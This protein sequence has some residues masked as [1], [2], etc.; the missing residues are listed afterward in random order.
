MNEDEFEAFPAPYLVT[1]EGV[2]LWMTEDG[3]LVDQDGGEWEF[4]EDDDSEEFSDDDREALTAEI[5]RQRD[6]VRAELGRELTPREN[7]EMAGA[8]IDQLA[9]GEAPNVHLAH[10]ERG[11][12]FDLDNEQDRHRYMAERLTDPTPP[13]AMPPLPTE[14]TDGE[15]HEWLQARMRGATVEDGEG[16]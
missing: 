13:D 14:A 4:A 3:D 15:R 8:L 11:E 16:E 7:A 5:M 2:P 12:E 1:D 10:M 9:R 6:E